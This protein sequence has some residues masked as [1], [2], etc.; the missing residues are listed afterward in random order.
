[1][2]HL[3]PHPTQV[4]T[5]VNNRLKKKISEQS[6]KYRYAF[7][8]KDYADFEVF[9]IT[10][11]ASV[12]HSNLKTALSRH[13]KPVV[14]FMTYDVGPS[15]VLKT[16]IRHIVC[17]VAF[18][19]SKETRILFFDMRDLADISPHHKKFIEKEIERLCDCAPVRL[20]NLGKNT[21]LQ[22][23]KG[24]TEMGWCIG[25]ALFFLNTAIA[26]PLVDDQYLADLTPHKQ[27]SE[28]KKLYKVIDDQLK[29]EKSNHLIEKWYLNAYNAT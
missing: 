9:N 17:C 4:S 10:G 25:W 2:K 5:K 26:R 19:S 12:D 23:F 18:P 8:K 1:M 27:E 21:Y 6:D 15:K 11:G 14:F 7:N 16:F 22:R 28:L 3:R 29:S 20:V 24:D 13:D